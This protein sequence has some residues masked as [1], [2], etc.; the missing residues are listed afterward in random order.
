MV[1]IRKENNMLLWLVKKGNNDLMN[2]II[3]WILMN[4]VWW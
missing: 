4:I 3:G 1:V 2:V